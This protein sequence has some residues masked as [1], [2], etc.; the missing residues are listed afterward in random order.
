M[1]RLG[2]FAAKYSTNST[3]KSIFLEIRSNPYKSQN[4]FHILWKPKVH[5][6]VRR[7]LPPVP[8]LNQMNKVNTMSELHN[9]TEILL[10]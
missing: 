7:K 5:Y 6:P 3:E 4:V 2:C 1:V 8:A 9:E 10:I